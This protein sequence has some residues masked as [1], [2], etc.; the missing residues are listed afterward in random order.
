MNNLISMNIV[1]L[2]FSIIGN[3]TNKIYHEMI[4]YAWQNLLL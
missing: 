2:H 1:Y 4:A 3:V